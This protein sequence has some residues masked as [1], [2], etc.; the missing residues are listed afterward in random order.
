MAI[1]TTINKF[2][3]IVFAASNEWSLWT[4]EIPNGTVGHRTRMPGQASGI[5]DCG[6]VS[7]SMYVGPMD[8]PFLWSPAIAN[9]TEGSTSALLGT[10]TRY[11]LTWINTF[12]QVAGGIYI[13]SPHVFLWTPNQSNGSSGTVNTDA[14]FRGLR[15][16]NDFGQAIINSQEGPMLFTPSEPNGTQG[17]FT[18]VPGLVP[19]DELFAINDHGT[20][21]GRFASLQGF[22]WTPDTAN[23]TS[24]TI[25]AIPFPPGYRSMYPVAL[26]ARGQAVGTMWGYDG[27][28]IPFLY[29]G[30]RIYDLSVLNSRFTG[31]KPNGINDRG[32]IVMAET[33]MLWLL[34]PRAEEFSRFPAGP[35]DNRNHDTLR[36]SAC[37]D[38][39][40]LFSL[41]GPRRRSE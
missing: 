27:P 34:T 30:G 17:S 26:N 28:D 1:G 39:D 6:Q 37:W 4:P 11:G 3:Q 32:Q 38:V 5:N 40:I 13:S 33:P 23:G 9:G 2:G 31:A 35:A 10:D 21:L 8:Q 41:R 7:G 20:V 24:G 29:S 14:R 16:I 36:G 25:A 15:A 22:L 18:P 19:G 12:G